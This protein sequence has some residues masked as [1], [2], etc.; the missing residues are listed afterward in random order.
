MCDRSGSMPFIH[1][2]QPARLIERLPAD[3][4]HADLRG[5]LVRLLI[6]KL[7]TSIHGFYFSK[8]VETEKSMKINRR[9]PIHWLYLAAF[10]VNVVLALLIRLCSSRRKPLVV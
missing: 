8:I 1:C 5:P 9:N 2:C 4:A 10:S 7:R 6:Q 3:H